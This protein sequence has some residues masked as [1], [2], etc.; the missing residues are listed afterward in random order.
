MTQWT[1]FKLYKHIYIHHNKALK[2]FR[3]YNSTANVCYTIFSSEKKLHDR[4]PP[5]LKLYMHIY[6]PQKSIQTLQVVQNSR[7][8]LFHT[9][10]TTEKKIHYRTPPPQKKNK[11]T[12]TLTV[13]QP[14]SPPLCFYTSLI[15]SGSVLYHTLPPIPKWTDSS[16]CCNRKMYK[17]HDM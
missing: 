4:P 11:K 17:R 9:M 1:C 6:T 2:Q 15:T 10:F 5:P 3:F 7:A 16:C 13:T 14:K 12:N 8:K